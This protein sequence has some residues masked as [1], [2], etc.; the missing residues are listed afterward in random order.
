[1]VDQE[2]TETSAKLSSQFKYSDIMALNIESKRIKNYL[3]EL[4][5][6]I[7]TKG[8]K[9]IIYIRNALLKLL[10]NI[11][12]NFKEVLHY[13]T[14]WDAMYLIR[15]EY[16]PDDNT[17]FIKNHS[18]DNRNYDRMSGFY[19]YDHVILKPKNMDEPV[20]NIEKIKIPRI[21]PKDVKL[22]DSPFYYRIL[23]QTQSETAVWYLRVIIFEPNDFEDRR[24]QT[25]GLSCGSFDINR[26]FPFFPNLNTEDKRKNTCIKLITEICNIANDK[27]IKIPTPFG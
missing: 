9:N 1:M 8:E 26:L 3:I 2:K 11:N 22:N 19:Y 18:S 20:K 13:K 12:Y 25:K 10:Q 24:K 5:T 27:K 17:N 21:I 14:F 4:S 23:S 15:N 7:T 6:A 16:Y